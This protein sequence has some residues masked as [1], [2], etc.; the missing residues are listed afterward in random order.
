MYKF[1]LKTEVINV[2]TFKECA[3]DLEITGNDM[4][5]TNAFIFDPFIR[6]LNLEAQVL[7]QEKY[8]AGEPSDE[9]IDA[10][11]K[12]IPAGVKRIIAVGGGTI[13]DISK[14]LVFKGDWS[15]QDI[16]TG[17]LIPKKER[18]LVV[19]PT[20]CGTG[21]EVTN[22]TITELKAL[23][24]KK[25]LAL[26]SLY[27]DKAY[28]IP[29]MLKTLPYKFFATS[30]IDA[31][32]HAME[33]YLSPKSI[34]HSEAYSVKAMEMILEGFS[35]VAKQGEDSWID[36]AKLFL[37]ASNLAGIAFGYAGCAAVHATS[38][39]LGGSYHIPHGEAN[40]LM[41]TPVLKMYKEKKANGK[42]KELENLI[43]RMLHVTSETALTEL[44]ALLEA[45]YPKQN[46]KAYGIKEEE[47]TLFARSVL[48]GQQ[49]L[50]QNNYV[51][52]TEE[53]IVEIYRDSF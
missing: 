20:T 52:L 6:A 15:T 32:I 49:R 19:V 53:E 4:I 3:Q 44:F 10:I 21:S 22:I 40:Q 25:G 14:V 1:S 9:M 46:L 24:T 35:Y 18:D 47:L 37:E 27:A 51:E 29:E 13:I 39:P 41:L 30:A 45:I 31:F 17:K 48:E 7:F 50:L 8:G 33:S 11:R 43:G 2:E 5:I 23:K 16:F 38:Y 42:I 36:K 26:D 12:D 34:V 28:L